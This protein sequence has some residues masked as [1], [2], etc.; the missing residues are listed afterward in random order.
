MV[1]G[2]LW[3]H[4]FVP[5]ATTDSYCLLSCAAY[6]RWSEQF[7]TLK[8]HFC[9]LLEEKPHACSAV[10]KKSHFHLKINQMFITN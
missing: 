1:T 8:G 3:L 2:Y 7:L 9:L 5:I 4:G 10:E 6:Q